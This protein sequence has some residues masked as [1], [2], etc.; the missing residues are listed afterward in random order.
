VATFRKP[1]WTEQIKKFPVLCL[2]LGVGWSKI[3]TTIKMSDL[4]HALLYIF[5]HC[6]QIFAQTF[7]IKFE[8]D[9]QAISSI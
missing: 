4:V 1:S 6:L 5:P 9:R 7:Q 2:E 8:R 3:I